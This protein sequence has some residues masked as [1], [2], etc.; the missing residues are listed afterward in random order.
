MRRSAEHER[1]AVQPRGVGVRFALPVLFGPVLNPLNTTMISVALVPIAASLHVTS[2][3][4]I[5]L[6]VALYLASAVSQPVMGSLA[7]LIGPRRVYLAGMVVVLIASAIPLVSHSFPAVLAARV[8][9]GVGTSAA[10][11]A[12]MTLIRQETLR[13]G[14]ATPPALLAGMSLSSLATAAV[15]PVLGGVLVAA[16]GWESIF[17]VNI[18]LAALTLVLLLVCLPADASPTGRPAERLLDRLDPVGIVLFAAATTSLLFFLLRLPDGPYWLLAVFVT[19]LVGLVLWERRHRRP[20]VDVR[21]LASNGAL[22][23]TYLRLGLTY[24]GPYIVVYAMSQWLQD[25][26]GLSSDTAG[27]VQFPSAVL[28][29]IASLTIARATRVRLPLLVAAVVPVAGG[30]CLVA[31]DSTSPLWLIVLAAT[32]FGIPQGLGAVANQAVVYRQAPAD[33]I[34]S[35]SGLSRTAVSLTAILSS[36]LIGLTFGSSPSDA[37]LHLLGWIVAGAG[38]LSLVL[39]VLDRSLR[40]DARQ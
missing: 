5:W 26:V 24:L 40:A 9:L 4:V 25:E 12:G 18:P 8:L 30:L 1:T 22:T 27:L 6:V 15:G 13:L 28:A 29:A 2:A 16:F 32:V 23:R 39:T 14:I 7:D 21:L 10:Y 3:T 11:P 33:Q 31:V 38:L 37:G 35:A 34:G 17:A 20:F 19:A 36:A